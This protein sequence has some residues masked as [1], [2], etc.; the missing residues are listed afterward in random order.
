M[1]RE[2]PA[3]AGYVHSY[4]SP[5]QLLHEE[6]VVE[7]LLAFIPARIQICTRIELKIHP[8]LFSAFEFTKRRFQRSYGPQL[9]VWA[10]L[11]S[12]ATGGVRFISFM[13]LKLRVS[14]IPSDRLLAGVLSTGYIMF[15][16]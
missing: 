15:L 4:T 9:P 1:A 2:I 13:L 8:D 11:T 3:Y 10:L 14:L 5:S 6:T 12:G 16:L 7:Y